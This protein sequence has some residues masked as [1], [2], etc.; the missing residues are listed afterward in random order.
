MRHQ[1]DCGSGCFGIGTDLPGELAPPTF[2]IGDC[3]D[4]RWAMLRGLEELI[5]EKTVSIQ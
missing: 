5:E 2:W 3:S 1:E 4:W